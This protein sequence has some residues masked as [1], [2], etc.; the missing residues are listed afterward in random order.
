M[1]K[2]TIGWLV[3]LLAVILVGALWACTDQRV[4]E[5]TYTA[6]EG[7]QEGRITLTLRAGGEGTWETSTDT[8]AFRWKVRKAEIWLHTRT[9]GVVL[10]KVVDQ[11]RLSV[12]VPG[13]GNVLFKRMRD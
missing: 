9:G 4:F 12:D 1:R 10:G 7:A 8:V 11:N 5:G 3:P 2:R 6:N 13:V